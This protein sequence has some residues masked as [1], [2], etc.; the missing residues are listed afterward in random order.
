MFFD[1]AE[2][3]TSSETY[4]DSL[5][6]VIEP[7]RKAIHRKCQEQSSSLN[8]DLQSQLDMVLI[9]L[10][11]LINPLQDGIDLN[12][13]GYSKEA[14]ATS[15][16]I[17]YNFRYN[18]KNKG[19]SSYKR[20]S[21]NTQPPFPLYVAVKLYSSIRSKTLVNWLYL[22]AG[23]SLPYK[24][25]LE[26][27]RDIANQM[28]SQY[29]RDGA[30]LRRTLRK[31]ILTIIAKN[32]VDQNSKSTT[33]TRH[34]HGTSLFIFQFPTEENPGIAVEYGDLENSSNRS[35]LKINALQS[36]YTCAKNF[37]TPLQTLTMPSTL[38]PT[39]FLT[40]PGT[41]IEAEYQTK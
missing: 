19:I 27:T 14:L 2:L 28:I 34:Y 10:L 37:L 36:S 20:H 5:V 29:D 8:V 21:K 35:S 7:V 18:T 16:T 30:F 13:K 9:E 40:T 32:N 3:S 1:T 15:Q 4:F 6:K 11:Q 31:G 25:L 17:M 24:S 23:I 33:A 38:P 22:C 26:L 41:F 39:T 12:D